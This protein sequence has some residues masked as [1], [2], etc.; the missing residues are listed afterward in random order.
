MPVTQ[1]RN[2][3]PD[4]AAPSC[5]TSDQSASEK[6]SLLAHILLDF[7]ANASIAV[8]VDGLFPRSPPCL[9]QEPGLWWCK[10]RDRRGA[11]VESKTMATRQTSQQAKTK[12]E[13]KVDPGVI[14]NKLGG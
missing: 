3:L 4:W 6:T 13:A 7:A 1:W 14:T 2:W 10:H 9:A 5:A 12:T 8:G 11:N